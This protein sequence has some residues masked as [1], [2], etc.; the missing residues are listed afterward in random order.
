[1]CQLYNSLASE[2]PSETLDTS[3]KK[4]KERIVTELEFASTQDVRRGLEVFERN[5][6]AVQE[7]KQFIKFDVKTAF[8]LAVSS[9]TWYAHYPTLFKIADMSDEEAEAIRETIVNG[10]DEEREKNSVVY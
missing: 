6:F 9:K 1:M 10:S 5:Q 8:L 7:N 3:A 4:N 2:D